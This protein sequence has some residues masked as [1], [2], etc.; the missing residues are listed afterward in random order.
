VGI[1][2]GTQDLVDVDRVAPDRP[3]SPSWVVVAT[4]L[5]APGLEDDEDDEPQPAARRAAAARTAMAMGSA[6]GIR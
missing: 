2:V 6:R 5:I 3:T 1:G 4:T